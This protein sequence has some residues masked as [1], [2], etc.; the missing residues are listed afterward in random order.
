MSERQ[1]NKPTWQNRHLQANRAD[2]TWKFFVFL[3]LSEVSSYTKIKLKEK[4][5]T[6]SNKKEIM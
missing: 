1:R 3:Q 5:Q 4:T 2:G 6:F